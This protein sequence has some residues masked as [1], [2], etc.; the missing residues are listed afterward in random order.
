MSARTIVPP[1]VIVVTALASVATMT[2]AA[3]RGLALLSALAAAAFG[4]AAVAIAVF[5]FF[6]RVFGDRAPA[7][8]AAAAEFLGAS[9]DNA[10]LIALVYAWGAAAL[11][12]VYTFSGLRW[13]H[14]WQYGTGMGV[15]A[16]AIAFVAWRIAAAD[17]RVTTPGALSAM[18][19]LARINA[20]AVAVG[21]AWL[22]LSGKLWAG[23]Y[24]WAANQVFVA[25]GL[26]IVAV[27]LIAALVHAR[28]APSRPVSPD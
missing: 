28:L 4:I 15:I 7:G 27:C 20:A 19:T 5:F 25:G 23:K 12:V 17:P 8:P 9:R 3:G 2:Y 11:I 18:A 10:L 1:L 6:L 26:A 21:I 24:D 13:Q 16:I 14:G 22:V